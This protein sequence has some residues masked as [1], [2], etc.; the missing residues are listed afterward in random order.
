VLDIFG[1]RYCLVLDIFGVRY[2]LVLDIVCFLFKEF[3]ISEKTSHLHCHIAEAHRHFPKWKRRIGEP[4][5]MENVLQQQVARL[6][7]FTERLRKSRGDVT[8]VL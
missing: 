2:C 8:H 4:S 1:V 5:V 3:D 6:W 7:G